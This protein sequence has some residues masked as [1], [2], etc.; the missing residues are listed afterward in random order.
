MFTMSRQEIVSTTAGPA[1]FHADFSTVTASKPAKAGEV[2]IVRATA[3]G[4]TRPG[5]IAG[6]PFPSDAF[7]Q[8]N[9][10]L[11]VLV[12]GQPAQVTNA[13]GWP[14]LGASY[15]LDFRGPEATTAGMPALSLAA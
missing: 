7:Q 1:I 11:V 14:R 10:P 5:V 12:N 8:V 15:R 13:I 2:L 4:P 6:Q 3:L 9:S